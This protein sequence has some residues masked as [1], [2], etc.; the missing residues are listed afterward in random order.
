MKATLPLD[1][2]LEILIMD[3]G[4]DQRKFSLPR[5]LSL[6]I[7]APLMVSLE[8]DGSYFCFFDFILGSSPDS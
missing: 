2:F 7:K 4:K 5:S 8:P 6:G 1:S 3:S